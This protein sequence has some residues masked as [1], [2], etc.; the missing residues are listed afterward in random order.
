[1]CI[2]IGEMNNKY[3]WKK[4]FMWFFRGKIVIKN[5][6]L[7]LI[8]LFGFLLEYKLILKRIVIEY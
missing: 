3:E 8:V 2:L 6:I 5:L 1:M 4:I 7:I